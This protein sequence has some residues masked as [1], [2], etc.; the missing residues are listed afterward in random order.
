MAGVLFFDRSLKAL[1][2]PEPQQAKIYLQNLREAATEHECSALST[3]L[4]NADETGFLAAV[5]D[6]S[7]FLREV[8]QSNPEIFGKPFHC[9]GQYFA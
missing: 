2:V 3:Y 8:T 1:T 4:N 7:P 6:C 5:L 9:A